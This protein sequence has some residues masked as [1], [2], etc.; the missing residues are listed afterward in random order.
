MLAARPYPGAMAVYRVGHPYRAGVGQWPEAAQLRVTPASAE[1]A[2]FWA[3]PEP[4][5]SAA[6]SAGAAQFAWVD[7]ERIAVLLARF[8]GDEAAWVDCPYHPAQDP[9]VRPPVVAAGQPLLVHVVLV[10]AGTGVVAALR[11]LTWPPGF[12][13]RVAQTVNR[14]LAVPAAPGAIDAV[15]DALYTRY[16]HTDDLLLAH[17]VARCVGGELG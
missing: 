8:G 12:A 15:L 16:P 5:E 11:T 4:G 7:V 14:L 3:R 6:V 10:D 13:H 1:L 2:L 9:Q 17:D